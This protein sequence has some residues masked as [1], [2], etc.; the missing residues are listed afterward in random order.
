MCQFYRKELICKVITQV[1]FYQE[2]VI[3]LLKRVTT[4]TVLLLVSVCFIIFFLTVKISKGSSLILI[5]T[6]FYYPG[7]LKY[8]LLMTMSHCEQHSLTFLDKDRQKRDHSFLSFFSLKTIRGINI[9]KKE[10][11]IQSNTFAL[12]NVR[13]CLFGRK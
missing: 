10:T 3:F 2:P 6:C 5:P 7:L 1:V 12:L 13:S 9:L 11:P 4:V 8:N